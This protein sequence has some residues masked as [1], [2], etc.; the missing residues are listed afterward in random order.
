MDI[1][2]SPFRDDDGSAD[3]GLAHAI[4][5]WLAGEVGDVDIALILRASRLM[6]PMVAVLDTEGTGV[7]GERVEKDSHMAMPLMVRPDGQRGLLAFTSMHAVHR[8]QSDARAVPVWGADAAAAALT[9][10]ADA[11]VVDVMGPVRVPVQ[12]RA[13]ELMASGEPPHAPP[14]G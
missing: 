1:P 8:W 5:R 9:E 10:G 4:D 7:T 3:L 12:G 13:L 2:A 14:Q 6:V 11:L